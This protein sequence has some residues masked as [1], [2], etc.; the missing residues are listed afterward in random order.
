MK[1]LHDKLKNMYDSDD[2]VNTSAFMSW[3][4]KSLNAFTQGQTLLES[5]P[6]AEYHARHFSEA[7]WGWEIK[8]MIFDLT[9]LPLWWRGHHV[10]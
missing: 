3:R 9:G 5:L 7:E 1:K 4:L 10:L 2:S 6:C 8:V